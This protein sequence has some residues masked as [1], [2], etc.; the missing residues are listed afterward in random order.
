M[1]L[2][3]RA[4]VGEACFIARDIALGTTPQVGQSHPQALRK[5]G[6]I[7]MEHTTRSCALMGRSVRFNHTLIT[8]TTRSRG[9]KGDEKRG[10]ARTIVTLPIDGI[11]HERV[12]SSEVL[13][14]KLL[15]LLTRSA[16]PTHCKSIRS[17]PVHIRHDV[18]TS[19][20]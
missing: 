3:K 18:K 11:E 6:E 7:K 10:G 2:E 17:N 5:L 15:A 8:L 4:T 1:P 14:V 19:T 13:K 12:E 20:I 9:E 16:M